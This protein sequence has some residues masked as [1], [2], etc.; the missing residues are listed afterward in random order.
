MTKDFPIPSLDGEETV[1]GI[2]A[3]GI[4]LEEGLNTSLSRNYCS[5]CNRKTH[6]FVIVDR[7]TK[8]AIFHNTCTKKECECRCRTHFACKKCG[9]LHP[10]GQKCDREQL[11]KKSNP[12]DDAEFEKIMEN[13]R[14]THQEKTTIIKKDS[15]P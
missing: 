3:S 7:K 9:F 4:E 5:N 10:H 1:V 6:C 12:K 8:E 13:W 14:K 2:H 15:K 11:S